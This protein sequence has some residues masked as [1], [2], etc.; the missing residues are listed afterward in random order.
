M[1]TEDDPRSYSCPITVTFSLAGVTG[2]QLYS[3]TLN[4]PINTVPNNNLM[5]SVS[6]IAFGAGSGADGSYPN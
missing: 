2:G 5:A 3:K 6:D 4:I 1:C